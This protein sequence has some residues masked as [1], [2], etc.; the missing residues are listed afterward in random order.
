MLVHGD[1][2]LTI[3]Y[4]DVSFCV[5]FVY[6]LKCDCLVQV[7][8]HT[9]EG[10]GDIGRKLSLYLEKKLRSFFFLWH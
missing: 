6:G 8:R 5:I 4:D 7:W 1:D 3:R 2:W 10:I 9:V